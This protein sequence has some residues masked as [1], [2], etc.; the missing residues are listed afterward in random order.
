MNPFEH[1]SVTISS[2]QRSEVCPPRNTALSHQRAGSS[3]FN[4]FRESHYRN[5]WKFSGSWRAIRNTAWK[6][7]HCVVGEW[8]TLN[9]EFVLSTIRKLPVATI[10]PLFRVLPNI[11]RLS[12]LL[13]PNYFSITYFHFCRNKIGLLHFKI[14]KNEVELVEVENI[15]M[16]LR[17]E[18]RQREEPKIMSQE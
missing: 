2:N 11:Q 10:E 14:N 15:S 7:M 8:C 5:E 4:E 1:K 13:F 12:K 17:W 16:I 18:L 9:N 6:T 3:H